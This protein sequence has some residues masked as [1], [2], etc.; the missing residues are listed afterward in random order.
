[1]V[2]DESLRKPI[3]E[4]AENARVKYLQK[5]ER[6]CAYRGR[7]KR[8]LGEGKVESIEWSKMG[9]R[10]RT[11]GRYRCKSGSSLREILG[12][13]RFLAKLRGKHWTRSGL[14]ERSECDER[15]TSLGFDLDFFDLGMVSHF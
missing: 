6:F 8:G 15:P 5:G 9:R 1:M 11:L 13:R 3:F 7:A 12:K 2:G 4:W 10:T 14:C